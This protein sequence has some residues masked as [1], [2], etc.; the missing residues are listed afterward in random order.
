MLNTRKKN[1]RIA[2]RVPARPGRLLRWRRRAL[3]TLWLSC[4]VTFVFA[5][6]LAGFLF[7]RWA[8]APVSS[9]AIASPMQRVDREELQSLVEGAIEGGFLSL[10][11]A[12]VCAALEAHPWIASASARRYWP[13]RLEVSV[14]EEVPIV[15]WGQDSFVNRRG[16]TLAINDA[17]SLVTLPHLSGPSGSIAEVMQE[18]RDVSELLNREGLKV[19]AFEMDAYRRWRVSLDAGFAVVLGQRDVPAKVRRFAQVWREELAARQADIA[20]VDA[21]YENGVAVSWR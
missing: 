18:Y 11:L 20:A 4:V 16:D 9:I 1:Q 8:D 17:D 5:I 10:D 15:R 21:R 19:V 2:P 6:T 7:Y 3:R 12:A 14:V 13:G